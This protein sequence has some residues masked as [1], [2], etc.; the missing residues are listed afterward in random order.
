MSDYNA[1]IVPRD[2][3]MV[4]YEHH[5]PRALYKELGKHIVEK[6]RRRL[7]IED[8]TEAING[9]FLKFGEPAPNPLPI[10]FTPDKD[11]TGSEN[12]SLLDRL[13]IEKVDQVIQAAR[14]VIYAVLHR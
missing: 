6:D 4:Y 3:V 12:I 14:T 9:Y 5:R 10:L 7:I 11:Y 13:P 8:A 1:D 2:A